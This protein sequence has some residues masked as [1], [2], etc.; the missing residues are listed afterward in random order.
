[1]PGVFDRRLIELCCPKEIKRVYTAYKRSKLD[2]LHAAWADNIAHERMATG[3]SLEDVLAL[4]EWEADFPA[5]PSRVLEWGDECK[6]IPLIR[7]P[8]GADGVTYQAFE[9]A[10]DHRAAQI[11]NRVRTGRYLFYPFRDVVALKRPLV[12]DR[13]PTRTEVKKAIDRGE[14]RTLSVASI[15]DAIVQRMLSEV[16]CLIR[17]SPMQVRACCCHD[18]PPPPPS[19]I[20][21]RAGCRP[22]QVL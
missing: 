9:N 22:L 20:C 12:E 8:M 11:A 10:I 21:A 13:K 14:V 19:R 17:V 7:I 15:R 16:P 2:R 3:A 18:G 5:C 4:E 6:E 1:M